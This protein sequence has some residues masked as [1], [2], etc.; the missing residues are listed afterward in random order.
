MF[1]F[2]ITCSLVGLGCSVEPLTDAPLQGDSHRQRYSYTV[3]ASQELEIWHYVPTEKSLD[4]ALVLWHGGGWVQGG[5]GSLDSY[6]SLYAQLGVHCLTPAY[7]LIGD[8]SQSLYPLEDARTF[9]QV[10]QKQQ[11]NWG[12]EGLSL[13]SGGS[14]AGATLGAHNPAQGHV[15]FAPVLQTVGSGAFHSPY[16]DS[17]SSSQYDVL[18]Q[19]G[20]GPAQ[21]QALPS[22]VFH[23]G[24][25]RTSPHQQSQSY[26]EHLQ[27]LGVPCRLHTLEGLGHNGIQSDIF[28]QDSLIRL[29]V[30]FMRDHAQDHF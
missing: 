22:I 9:W 6:C 1:W 16:L 30:Q 25:D 21:I 14:S 12:L 26:C 11:S 2:A 23:G 17:L 24:Q 4:L 13:W 18:S 3:G 5:P 20:T 8:S 27:E 29:S 28:L 15:F 10:L 19:L 7:R